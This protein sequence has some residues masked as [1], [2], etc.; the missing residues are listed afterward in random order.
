[1]PVHWEYRQQYFPNF[2]VGGDEGKPV[3]WNWRFNVSEAELV[4]ANEAA[5]TLKDPTKLMRAAEGMYPN[6][7]P[8]Y[9]LKMFFYN[10]FGWHFDRETQ[11]ILEGVGPEPHYNSSG[12]LAIND[13]E[14]RRLYRNCPDVLELRSAT[15]DL[16][17]ERTYHQPRLQKMALDIIMNE[18][19]PEVKA[20]LDG[21]QNRR[22]P[23]TEVPRAYYGQQTRRN[24]GASSS[25][26]RV[27]R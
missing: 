19:S 8:D 20:I 27:I 4:A 12:A 16:A 5:C 10:V 17:T 13:Q 6:Q 22:R 14:F 23:E 25:H 3:K 18:V 24:D 15:L 9:G 2:D 1:M 11:T 7:P 21:L 26:S